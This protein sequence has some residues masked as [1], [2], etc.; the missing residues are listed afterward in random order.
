[1]LILK[2]NMTH[3]VT[4]NINVYIKPYIIIKCTTLFLTITL[5]RNFE[6]YYNHKNVLNQNQ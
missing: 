2:P 5:I 1:M 3:I 4:I 6:P